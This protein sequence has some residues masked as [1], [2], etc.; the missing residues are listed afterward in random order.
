MAQGEA[1]EI[2]HIVV[3]SLE[4]MRSDFAKRAHRLRMR[5]GALHTFDIANPIW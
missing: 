1:N 2:D 4:R 5:A 3:Q